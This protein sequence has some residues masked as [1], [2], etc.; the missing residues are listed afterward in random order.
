MIGEKRS[1]LVWGWLG[2]IVTL[3]F[4]VALKFLIE[5]DPVL[6]ETVGDGQQIQS[7]QTVD[8]IWG[9]G[10]ITA[11]I[12]V[13]IDPG[14]VITIAPNTTIR[15]A[16]DAGIT[17]NGDLRTEGPVVFTGISETPGAWS[18]VTYASGSTGSLSGV[19]IEYAQHA[20]TLDTVNP[21]TVTNS[22]LR[23]NRHAPVTDQ[24]AFGAGLTIQQGS[25]LVEGTRIY[26]NTA[27]AT[28][29]GEVR[30]AGIYIGAGSPRI[31]GSWIYENTATGVITGA[32]GGIA[33]AGGAPV[34]EASYVTTNTLAG[35]G[36]SVLKSGGGIGFVGS[37]TAEIRGCWIADNRND[38]NGGYAGGGGI[39]FA[40]NAAASLIE[41]SVIYAN[42]VQGP[43]WCEG[44]GIDAWEDNAVVI[45][46]NLILSNTS[47]SCLAGYGAYGGGANLYGSGAGVR[48]LNNTI[49]GNQAGRGGGLYLQGGNVSA[50][51][52]VVVNNTATII[53][54]VGGIMREAGTANYND[55]WG[56]TTPQTGGIMGSQTLYVDPLFLETGELVE[57]YH[58]NQLS[59][60]I[61]AGT[62]SSTGLP[63]EDYDGDSRPLGSGWDMGFDEVAPS[64][65]VSKR[66]D[67]EPVEAGD[68]LTYTILISNTGQVKAPGVTLY[69]PLPLH[70]AYVSGSS[71][72]SLSGSSGT[73]S[74]G[75][76]TVAFTGSNGTLDWSTQPWNEIGESDG[77]AGGNVMVMLDGG[78]N[79]IRIQ[80]DGYG[81]AR[82]ADLSRYA[83]ATL[84]FEYRRN[85]FDDANDYVRL[86][87]SK[88]GGA[89][90][91]EIARYS[92]PGTDGSYVAAS[93]DISTYIAADTMIQFVS[94]GLAVNDR[95]FVD[96]VQ[97][98]ANL[99]PVTLAGGAPPDL[100]SVAALLPG[101][102]IGRAS[103][104]ERV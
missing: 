93:Y 7:T 73:Y 92:G 90:W 48:V 88:D 54:G 31:V 22:T 56:N 25:H 45:R 81:V 75:L 53:D 37:T 58:L 32:G 49:V 15:V 42:Y 26:S 97:I 62:N 35:S 52:N 87:V 18:G 38:L 60:L 5:A 17:V 51:N 67:H 101:R 12:A 69:N 89:S 36:S 50:L 63:T 59:P 39:G 83:E 21:V 24:I 9:P 47:G 71:L 13:V 19:T 80:R 4:M 40:P 2:L 46:N 72:V 94:S 78:D 96:N 11:P 14:V 68:I 28:G 64:L 6:A 102:E 91:T 82:L 95:F 65:T 61:D 33:I 57:Y 30:G 55:I 23:Y 77:A 104:R 16:D 43:E 100:A 79:S 98:A 85:G 103:C 44:S 86:L 10:V 41:Q 99:A 1:R 66:A 84:T 74:D 8:G 76:A 3:L 29:A 27:T 20:L 70:T 34:I